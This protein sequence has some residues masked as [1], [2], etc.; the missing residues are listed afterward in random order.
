MASWAYVFTCDK[1]MEE[2]LAA[3]QE[4]GPWEWAQRES[5][6][7][8][9]YLNTRPKEGLRVRIHAFPQMG[10]SGA[11]FVGP[12]KVNGV[13]YEKGFYA[14]MEIETSSKATKAEIDPVI[15][16]LLDKIAVANLRDAEPY[17]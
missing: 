12:G 3:F 11:M 1:A 10:E 7:Y 16:G 17:D 6:W 8:G 5:G 2:I 15:R 4:A 9:D 13:A 14:L